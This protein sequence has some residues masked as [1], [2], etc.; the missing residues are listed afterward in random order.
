MS[1]RE[2]IDLILDIA[3]TV[4]WP[5][6]VLVIAFSFRRT[7]RDRI[8]QSEEFVLTGPGGVGIT[9]R[10]RVEAADAL[11]K[12]SQPTGGLDRR[13]A[14]EQVGE[15]IRTV[16]DFGRPPRIL[17]VDDRPSNNTYERQ[18]MEKL[19]MV[20]ELSTSTDDALAKIKAREPYDAI[21][22][23]MGR[24]PDDRAGYTLLDRLRLNGDQTPF[25]I[26]ASSRSQEHFDES[27]RHGAAGCTNR[28]GELIDLVRRA[29][30][31][32]K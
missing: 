32:A 16:G 5:I 4:I 31:V 9:A 22:S 29:L 15:I 7:I 13:E 27:V 26:Y 3:K 6:V 1:T 30:R 23:D 24:P 14:F 10:G 25:V 21:I 19:G 12:A 18:A 2:L 28:P 20:F 8:S 11:I 17:W